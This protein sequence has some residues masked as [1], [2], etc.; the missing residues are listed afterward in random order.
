M[1]RD[2]RHYFKET[3]SDKDDSLV[4]VPLTDYLQRDFSSKHGIS[5]HELRNSLVFYY[6]NVRVHLWKGSITQ[7]KVDAIINAANSSLMGGGGVDGAIH[8]AAG[9]NLKR[10]CRKFGGCDTGNAVITK[11]YN[12]PSKT[13]IHTVG[14][15]IYDENKL[16]PKSLSNCYKNSF[17]LCE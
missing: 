16:K 2:S 4:N 3:D 10:E 5:P 15:I 8:Y 13:V 7:L 11:G 6:K 14:P 1:T 9:P 12:L 17:K